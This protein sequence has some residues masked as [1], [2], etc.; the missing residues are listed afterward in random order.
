MRFKMLQS[1]QGASLF[2]ADREFGREFGGIRRELV[3]RGIGC[4][5]GIG[6]GIDIGGGSLIRWELFRVVD[7]VGRPTGILDILGSHGE[8]V[9]RISRLGGWQ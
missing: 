1:Y 8:L 2:L 3:I 4:S 5:G 6:I 9:M 7:G